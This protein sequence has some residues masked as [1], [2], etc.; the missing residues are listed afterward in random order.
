MKLLMIIWNDGSLIEREIP[1]DWEW[2]RKG[3]ELIYGDS[4][5]NLRAI[6]NLEYARELRMGYKEPLIE[7]PK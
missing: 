6:F 4:G 2:T 5:R 7:E 3:N 1:D